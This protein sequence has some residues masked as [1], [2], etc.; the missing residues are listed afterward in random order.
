MLFRSAAIEIKT[1]EEVL[2]NGLAEEVNSLYGQ[3]CHEV[4]VSAR[5]AYESKFAGKK[6]VSQKTL[7]PIKIIREKLVGLFFLDPS[8]AET[9]QSIDDT[10]NRMPTCGAIKGPDLN[11]VAGLVGS[12]LANMGRDLPQL[13]ESET[14][15]NDDEDTSEEVTDEEPETEDSLTPENPGRVEPIT[16]DF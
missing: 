5:R 16:W 1:P 11:M 10:M 14:E 9:I 15:G 6:E 12:Q 3:L 8:I 2:A 7:R 4:R 13:Q